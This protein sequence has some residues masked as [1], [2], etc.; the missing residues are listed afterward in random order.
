MYEINYFTNY[1]K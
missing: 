1:S